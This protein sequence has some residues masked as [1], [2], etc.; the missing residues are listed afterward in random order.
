MHKSPVSL[1]VFLWLLI[2]AQHNLYGQSI[3][4]RIT[5]AAGAPVVGATLFIR[6]QNFGT[7]ANEGGYYELKTG[8]GSFA[9]V[10]QC[11][12][13]ETQVHQ[14]TVGRGATVQNITLKEQAYQIGTVTVTNKREDPA[15][16]IMRRVIAMAPYYLN[17]VASYE[18]DVYLKGSLHIVKIS[19]LVKNLAK[20]DL[21]GYKDGGTYVEESFSEVEF[22]APNKYKQ[23]VKKR[24]GSF[25]GTD[26]MKIS[27]TTTSIY[28]P[29]LLAGYI[30]PLSPGAFNHYN[31]RYDGFITQNGQTIKK[32][33]I[34]PKRRNKQLIAGDIY[35]I[36]SFWNVYSVDIM[37][38][39]PMGGDFRMR[40]NFGE[41]SPNVWLPIS[42][43]VDFHAS[44]MGNKGEYRYAS[45]VKYKSIV[46]NK[47]LSKP[48]PI[49]LA[50]QLRREELEGTTAAATVATLPIQGD[51]SRNTRKIEEILSR[52][53]LS[54]REAYK[55]ANLMQ[56][57]AEAA[58]D[59]V[60]SLN[61][62]ES[63]YTNY[64]FEVDSTARR[65]DTLFW[66]EMRPVPLMA[67]EITSYKDKADAD[68]PQAAGDSTGR[69][70]TP[71]K[72]SSFMN[73]LSGNAPILKGSFGSITYNGL[74]P[75]QS[76]F[77]TV[78]G[79]YIRQGLTYA[80]DFKIGEHKNKLK[81][82]PEVV[83]AI[84]RKTLMWN[85]DASYDYAPLRRGRF[86][87]A[88]GRK[89]SDF[90]GET[91]IYP[92]ENAVASLFFRRNYMKLYEQ[93]FVRAGNTIDLANGLQLTASVLYSK[94][95]M[96]ENSTDYSFFFRDT[97]EYTPNVPVNPELTAPL[98]DHTNA[99]FAVALSYTPRS[100]YRIDNRGRKQT[101]RSNYPT[102]SAGW[103]KG[104]P[105]WLGSDSRYDFV[106]AG[107]NQS[108]KIGT[109]Q[110][111]KYM[112]TAGVFVNRQQVF[113]PDFRHFRT[114]DIPVT[115]GALDNYNFNLLEY[116][117]YSTSDRFVEAHLYY[118]TPFLLLKY[119]P[120]F[121]NR[122][123][124]EGLQ[125]NYLTTPLFKHYSELGYT[126]GL[127]WQAGVFVGFEGLKY[128]NVGFRFSLPILG[129]S[130]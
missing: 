12:G 34:I 28:N 88:F 127:I 85:V 76:G 77:N 27:F 69:K 41:V 90:N 43:N 57:E 84:N 89:T 110:Q 72:F 124:Q 101:V 104:I 87:L 128:R 111:F 74:G 130:E 63:Y 94:R 62:S 121:S 106:Y 32:I 59:S 4:G 52:E 45:S 2:A 54:N 71:G 15:Y 70:K 14:I 95:T 125:Y 96:L 120:F 118:T 13:Y 44:L 55:L 39:L 108:I 98:E 53:T 20:D 117:R 31:F 68:S 78:D 97:R 51:P 50:E 61:L 36:D 18:A 23:T 65:A 114:L 22:T 26:E 21:K 107:I 75:S 6:E 3:K 60:R 93:N 1:F 37:G 82:S 48:D 64:K 83:W 86:T 102:L 80:K 119:L 113:F 105:G 46:E 81:I 11:L 8:E 5:D 33:N 24:T 16:N 17:Q 116:Y 47:S 30:S 66:K 91:G 99:S 40:I 100:Y 115:L 7:T 112:A 103:R 92:L 56:K 49:L 25:P 129:F 109:M 35:I 67:D 79:Y 9:C 122:F 29:Q 58:K 38:E 126:I 19:R 123:W 42:H 10:F 73:K